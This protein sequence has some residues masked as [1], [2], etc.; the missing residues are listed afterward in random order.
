MVK[1]PVRKLETLTANS[2]RVIEL[3]WTHASREKRKNRPLFIGFTGHSFTGKTTLA[4]ALADHLR[5]L[6]I[7]V[8]PVD[9]TNFYRKKSDREGSSN[10]ASNYFRSF[11][12]YGYM[13]RELID[14]CHGFPVRKKLR[15]L[16]PKTDRYTIEK[17][18]EI[19]CD[20]VVIVD[21]PFLNRVEI[22]DYFDY[23]VFLRMSFA[24]IYN[25]LLEYR[26]TSEGDEAC[27]FYRAHRFPAEGG[28]TALNPPEL[29]ANVT[30]LTQDFDNLELTFFERYRTIPDFNSK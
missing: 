3:I 23:L 26:K 29:Y 9:M 1:Q 5:S 20:T 22:R 10:P 21:G 15:H 28:F 25:R 17:T 6:S 27:E 24:D 14:P 2:K 19:D 16:E 18:Y 30:I 11:F 4:G 7:K 13:V 12:D 8:Q